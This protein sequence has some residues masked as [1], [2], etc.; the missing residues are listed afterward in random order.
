MFHNHY[1]ALIKGHEDLSL[2]YERRIEGLR[3]DLAEADA[4]MNEMGN[5]L[6][7]YQHF[8]SSRGLSEVFKD[9]S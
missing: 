4:T 9:A 6:N 5:E 2:E 1:R 8:V 3:E 7:R